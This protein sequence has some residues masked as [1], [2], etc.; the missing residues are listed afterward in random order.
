M[1]LDTRNK[2]IYDLGVGISTVFK[3][4]GHYLYQRGQ[5][6]SVWSR[7]TYHKMLLDTRNKNI[8]GLGVG[9][10]MI[11]EILGHSLLKGGMI[12]LC[13]VMTYISSDAPCHKKQGY[14]W[15]RGEDFNGFQDICALPLSR[16]TGTLHMVM[17]NIPSDAT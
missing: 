17:T 5:D 13:T 15:L 3:I 11:F 10:S 16:G 2:N 9:I 6:H 14:I 1:L 7:P 8:Y 12:P 4:F